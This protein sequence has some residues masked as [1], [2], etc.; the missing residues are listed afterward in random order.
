MRHRIIL[1]AWLLVVWVALWRDV[2][3]ANVVTG[4]L[5]A[6]GSLVG[7][8]VRIVAGWLI[9]RMQNADL[10]AVAVMIVTGSVGIVLLNSG[11]RVGLY[12]GALL[13]FT[14]GW[15]WAGLFTFAVVKDNPD[16]PAAA[17][18]VTQTGKYLGAALG[19]PVFGL[20]AD[21]VSFTAAWWFSTV[22]LLLA[23][24]LILYVR[25]QRAT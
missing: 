13:A 6:A 19:P 2:S 21:R 11:G 15:G 8:V 1:V 5:L 4:L 12:A 16:A 22:V 20:I 14:A 9:D 23:A 18:G 25:G 17:S 24:S 3:I 10:T 7:L